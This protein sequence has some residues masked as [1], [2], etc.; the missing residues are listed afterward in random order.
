[1]SYLEYTC[2]HTVVL[3]FVH[4]QVFQEMLCSFA[5][6]PNLNASLPSP[7]FLIFLN[8][9]NEYYFILLT[10][11]ASALLADVQDVTIVHLWSP[12]CIIILNL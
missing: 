4:D 7:P 6:L 11:A 10:K 9:P 3:T 2:V 1:M 12:S 8:K 5:F